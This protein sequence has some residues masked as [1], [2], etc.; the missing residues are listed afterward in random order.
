VNGQNI[1]MRDMLIEGVLNKS[2]KAIC[3]SG[4]VSTARA[5]ECERAAKLGL[6]R[7]VNVL[8]WEPTDAGR[9]YAVWGEKS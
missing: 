6:M 1:N 5:R 7:E 3:D 2:V 8:E 9:V 4:M